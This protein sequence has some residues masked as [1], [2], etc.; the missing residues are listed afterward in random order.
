MASEWYVF[1]NNNRLGPFSS[2]DLRRLTVAGS[3]SPDDLVWKEG[4]NGWIPA[5]NIKG[6]FSTS[7]NAQQTAGHTKPIV[8][9][10]GPSFAKFSDTNNFKIGISFRT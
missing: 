4:I 10:S 1:K 3:L 7:P 5:Q 2:Q 6:L 9:T 8:T